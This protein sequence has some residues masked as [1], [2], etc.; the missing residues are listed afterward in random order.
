MWRELAQTYSDSDVQ[1]LADRQFLTFIMVKTENSE[2][3]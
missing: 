3:V 2:E 1:Q